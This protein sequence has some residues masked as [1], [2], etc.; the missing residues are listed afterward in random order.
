[1]RPIFSSKR[2]AIVD[3]VKHLKDSEELAF[4]Y[5]VEALGVDYSR[6]E[7]ARRLERAIRSHLQPLFSLKHSSQEFS[8]RSAWTTV[9][10][11]RR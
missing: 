6:W 11:S 4:D 7:H 3:V 8:S 9:R 5:F 2:D 10:P 1:M